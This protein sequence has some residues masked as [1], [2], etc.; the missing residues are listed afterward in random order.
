MFL[1]FLSSVFLLAGD[2]FHL[3]KRRDNDVF[4]ESE[5]MGFHV[6]VDFVFFL[7]CSGYGV[8]LFHLGLFLRFG[9]RTVFGSVCS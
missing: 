3:F 9:L 5:S 8:W 2:L 7:L 6:F 4:F 1:K